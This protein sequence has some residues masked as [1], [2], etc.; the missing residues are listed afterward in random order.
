MGRLSGRWKPLAW[1]LAGLLGVAGVVGRGASADR[2]VASEAWDLRVRLAWGGGTP[3]IWRGTIRVTEGMLS[4]VTPLGLEP[5]AAAAFFQEGTEAIRVEPRVAR[6]YDGCDVRIQ[7]PADARLM[8]QLAAGPDG[9]AVS[10]E[11][12]LSRLVGELLQF[13]L[14]DRNNRLYAQRAPGDNLRVGLDTSS[15]V[16]QPTERLEMDVRA[17]HAGL[18]PGGTYVLTATLARAREEQTLWSEQYELRGEPGGGSSKLRLTVRLPEEEGAYDIKLALYPRRLTGPL[19][20]GKPLA[21]R[22]VQVVVVAPLEPVPPDAG[23]WQSVW[24]IDPATPRWWERMP[25]LSTLTRLP[26]LPRPLENMPANIRSHL[27]RPWV[28]LPPQGWQAYPLSVA[29]PGQPH[30]LEVEYPSDVPQS[31]VLRIVEPAADGQVSPLGPEGGV[32]VPPPAAGHR[33]RVL[34]H[35]LVFWPQ[36]R[37]PYLLVGNRREDRPALFGRIDLQAGPDRLPPLVAGPGSGGGRML[38]AYYD[39]PLFAFQFSASQA[40]DPVSQRALDDWQTFLEAGQRL[41]QTLHYQGYNALVL[42]VACEGSSLYPSRVLQP[43]PKYDTGIFLEGGQD[44]QRKDVLE[45]L[46][47]LCDRSGIVLV[48]A[49]DFSFPLPALEQLRHGTEE[50]AVGL[51]PVGVDGRTYSQRRGG[52]STGPLYNVLDPRVQRAMCDVVAELAQRYA[53]HASFGGVGVHLSADSF[54]L[55]PDESF[56][57]DEAT[58]ERFLRQTGTVLS[59]Q[60]VATPAA[61][62]AFLHRSAEPAWLRWRAEQVAGLLR[63]M[64]EEVTRRRPNGKLV[65][66]TAHLLGGHLAPVALRPALPPRDL[67]GELLPRLGL[68]LPWLL[69]DP[70]LVLPRPQ[71]LEPTW[72]AGL[73]DQSRHWNLE[74]RLDQLWSRPAGGA[75]L[76]CFVAAPRR[77]TDFDAQ[78]PFGPDQSRIVLLSQLSPSDA[79]QRER[80][81]RSLAAADVSLI[82][83][84]GWMLPLGQEAA[85]A[86][87][88]RL[89]RRLPAEP[90]A[91]PPR[92]G[93]PQELVV[94]TLTR[95]QRTWF[96][97]LNPTP[98][99]LQATVVFAGAD[100]LQLVPWEEQPAPAWEAREG[101]W[102][103]KAALEPYELRAGELL[104]GAARVVR[105]SVQVPAEVGTALSQQIRETTRR[106][107]QLKAQPRP[108]PLANAQFDLRAADGTPGDWWFARGAGLRVAVDPQGGAGSPACL[109]LVRR[110]AEVPLWVRSSP[111]PIP[112]TGR[113]QMAAALRVPDAAAQPRLRLAVEGRWQGQVYYRRINVGQ[114]ERPDDPTP[115][116]LTTQWARFA[117]SVPDLPLSGLTD[118]RVGFDLMS[119]GEVWIDEVQVFDAWLEDREYDE[120][121]KS[122]S[123]ARLQAETGRFQE[124]RLFLE[125]YWPSLLRRHV[126]LEEPPA[127]VAPPATAPPPQ[128]RRLLPAITGRGRTSWLPSPTTPPDTNPAGTTRTAEQEKGWLPSW[129]RWR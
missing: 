70:A 20:R 119:D 89:F 15:L 91:T 77:L 47:R 76:H 79:A 4:E 112:P 18:T 25:R 14:D 3:Q 81:A 7:A 59:P 75:A 114:A 84:G 127:V 58:F 117:I 6:S 49:V 17:H 24:Q 38:A 85:L 109:H 67:P 102:F 50:Q 61:R 39:K 30:C 52:L 78:N 129:L 124:C 66:L 88:V 94:R 22:K 68:E 105:W 37:N 57:L 113:L 100:P 108:L 103:W 73:H 95:G 1:F 116:G 121:L 63:Q 62:A 56:S 31:L 120:L 98:W 104:G 128:A 35:R 11:W 8:V 107:H 16:F 44:P 5:D 23:T 106:T 126:S 10:V 41:I 122:V 45:L 99:P 96:Y 118:L 82:L 65:V 64:G 32:E 125:S 60:P 55:L 40:V 29:H 74:S 101:H 43:T 83:D 34:R 69:D 36:T 2:A 90:F 115:P 33:P 26:V 19:I 92:E 48:P 86:N 21:A 9:E 87:W 123:A 51:E 110:G 46:L 53:H 72:N 54:L 71:R 42:T 111:L 93:Q 12:A 13:P 80:F 97:V 27:E 28:E